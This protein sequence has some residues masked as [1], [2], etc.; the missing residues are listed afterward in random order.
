[1]HHFSH[2]RIWAPASLLLLAAL[3]CTETAAPPLA[4][5]PNSLVTAPISVVVMNDGSVALTNVR[6]YT[7]EHDSLPIITSLNPGQSTTATSVHAAH[8]NPLVRATVNGQAIVAHPV[9][10]FSGWNAALAPGAYVLRL[11][12][13]PEHQGLEPRMTPANP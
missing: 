12:F 2:I 6:V 8:T 11:R 7:S 10:G 9:E 1:M 4:V 5:L 3:A 13:N